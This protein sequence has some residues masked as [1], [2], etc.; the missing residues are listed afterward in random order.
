MSDSSIHQQI[1][2]LV[3]KSL[4]DDIEIDDLTCFNVNNISD[5]LTYKEL[6]IKHFIDHIQGHFKNRKFRPLNEIKLN[7]KMIRAGYKY[8]SENSRRI[9]SKSLNWL[10][11]FRLYERDIYIYRNIDRQEIAQF[12][13]RV[14]SLNGLFSFIIFNSLELLYVEEQINFCL[15]IIRY[16]LNKRLKSNF[17]VSLLNKR[18]NAELSLN[19]KTLILCYDDN[20]L[21]ECKKYLTNLLDDNMLSIEGNFE[22][23]DEASIRSY[24]DYH[25]QDL[26]FEIEI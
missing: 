1:Y 20:T 15:G 23:F 21:K 24:L 14:D 9:F 11:S 16:E 17:A 12:P 13:D 6:Y 10:K 22:Y 18:I 8:L 26:M 19:I 25:K 2:D 5:T 7:S 4:S 3:I